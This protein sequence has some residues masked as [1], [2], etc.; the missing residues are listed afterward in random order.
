MKRKVLLFGILITLLAPISAAEA[1][2]DQYLAYSWE[3]EQFKAEIFLENLTR[4]STAYDSSKKIQRPVFYE[5]DSAFYQFVVTPRKL[6]IAELTTWIN[7]K[8]GK[9]KISHIRLR[10]GL[11]IGIEGDAIAGPTYFFNYFDQKADSPDG[12]E[13]EFEV[14]TNT[15]IELMALSSDIEIEFYDNTVDAAQYDYFSETTR[16]IMD[17]VK[18]TYLYHLGE[19]LGQEIL[20]P[21]IS[22]LNASQLGIPFVARSTSDLNVDITNLSPAICRVAGE[23]LQVRKAGVCN[24]L[25]SAS[26]DEVFAQ[27]KNKVISFPVKQ[28]KTTSKICVGETKIYQLVAKKKCDA[29]TI[30]LG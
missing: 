23:K 25:L 22:G 14:R 8:Y 12:L 15:D 6:P 11:F 20:A 21:T 4:A 28:S 16:I 1:E 19:K 13:G 26:G 10:V 2:D 27:A 7:S 18:P 3:T 30:T 9:V 5:G 17:D 29:G 24:I